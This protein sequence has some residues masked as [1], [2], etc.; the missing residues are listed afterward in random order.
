M[1]KISSLSK[2]STITIFLRVLGAAL[3]LSLQV[4]LARMLGVK[5]YGI[6]SYVISWI[7]IISL[8]GTLGF[9]T[10][11]ARF[12]PVY[13]QQK[14]WSLFQGIV[15]YSFKLTLVYSVLVILFIAAVLL[16]S[17]GL[18]ASN[19]T[20][21]FALPLIALIVLTSVR[22]AL[23]RSMKRYVAALFPETILKPLLFI[24]LV[25]I[26]YIYG[27]SLSSKEAVIL[28]ILVAFV[29]FIVASIYLKKIVHNKIRYEEPVYKKKSWLLT[30]LP[31]LIISGSVY[32]ISQADIIMLGFLMDYSDSGIYA[33]SA[34]LA[35]LSIFFMAAV[36]FVIA[37]MISESYHKGD[38]DDLKILVLKGTRISF[39]FSFL[40]S[41]FFLSYGK[42]FLNLFGEEFIFGYKALLILIFGHLVNAASGPVGLLLT[43]TGNQISAA[44]IMSVCVV[45][46]LLL[47][48]L[49]IPEFGLVG[50]ALSTMIATVFWN[51]VMLIKVYRVLGFSSFIL[52]I[53]RFG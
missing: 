29:S 5:E 49:F 37:P 15:S 25:V 42:I 50:A 34:R 47:N 12:V 32:I 1:G 35:E 53:R 40:V 8:I 44:K 20:L 28:H 21:L 18:S 26:Y 51:I 19:T 13:I 23:L 3:V 38:I 30:S 10:T 7:S 9:D 48:F 33:S 16:P 36:N 41:L 22:I 11:L 14:Q 52:G 24:S 39:I 45:I 17:S 2:N 43:L 31:A 4:L 6:Y 46:N 27:V